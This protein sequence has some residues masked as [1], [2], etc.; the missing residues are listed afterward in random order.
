MKVIWLLKSM[1]YVFVKKL[2]G[3]DKRVSGIAK[4]Y[5]RNFYRESDI[6]RT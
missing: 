2:H 5:L 3:N 6:Y 4:Q 1:G